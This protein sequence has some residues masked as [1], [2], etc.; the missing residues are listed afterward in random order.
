MQG[1]RV[2]VEA[3]EKNIA[4]M[5]AR[6]R[7]ECRI[8]HGY[9]I[10]RADSFEIIFYKSYREC[11]CGSILRVKA[12]RSVSLN[13][14][15]FVK[16]LYTDSILFFER[17]KIRI[18]TR[19]F[20]IDSVVKDTKLM[21]VEKLKKKLRTLKRVYEIEKMTFRTIIRYRNKT[22]QHQQCIDSVERVIK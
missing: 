5:N 19:S 11:N 9:N 21:S 7:V 18:E 13:L 15:L 10:K 3:K 14:F 8:M 12:N 17:F 20:I 16:R 6:V 2:S 22:H 1:T 4:R